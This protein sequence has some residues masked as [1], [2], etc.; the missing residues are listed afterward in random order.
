MSN[1]GGRDGERCVDGESRTIPTV[2]EETWTNQTGDG[3]GDPTKEKKALQK[4]GI[5]RGGNPKDDSLK[6]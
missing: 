3:R 4:A 5:R 6:R 1:Q 2:E